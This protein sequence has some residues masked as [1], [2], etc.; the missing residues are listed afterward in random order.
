M[1]M[2]IRQVVTKM[3]SFT[4]VSLDNKQSTSF[5]KNIDKYVDFISWCRWYPD[6][7]LDLIKPKTGGITLHPD[8]RL[9]LRCAVRFFALYGCFPRGWGKTWNEV[10]AMVIV[11]IFYPNMSNALTA[12]T[13]DNAAE[14]L[15]D[16]INELLKQY[17]MLEN[18]LKKKPKFQRGD[19]EVSLKDGSVLDVLANSQ[20]SKGQRRRRLSVEESALL[21]NT[22]F[23]DALKPIVEVSRYTCGKLAIVDPEELNQQI[24]FFTTPG[25]RGSD[26]HTRNLQMIK[27][28]ADLKGEIVLGSNWML[29]CWY[30]RGSSKS[31][32]LEKKKTMSP[33]AFDQNYGG[34]WTGS[35]D[36]ALV[37]I[38]RLMACR[39]L[40][41]PI[42]EAE[43]KDDEYYIGVDVA[44]SQNTNNNQSSIAIGKVN[45]NSNTGHMTS[46][47]IVNLLNVSNTI[48]FTNQACIIKKLKKRYNAQMV[49]LDGNGL[50]TG[51]VDEILKESIDPV[52]QEPLGCWDTVNTDNQPET[53]NAEKCLYDL[54]ATGMQTQ[55]I[56][57]FMSM[58]DSGKLR[59]LAKKQESELA[60]YDDKDLE[61][62]VVP[63]IQT[64]LLFEEVSNL[65]LKTLPSG[66]LTVEKVVGKLNKDRFS[67]L[68]YL[69]WYILEKD[70]EIVSNADNNIANFVKYSSQ[71]NGGINN[72][73]LISKIFR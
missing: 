71:I 49:I 28:M 14:L 39:V 57:D 54:K 64:D 24:N 59:L 15:K 27:N 25:W 60:V 48:N 58:I 10:A 20:N 51:L 12:Q 8:Q 16:K 73:N 19:A 43:N 38:N 7:F 63:F 11:G 35:S 70:K 3:S 68:A 37:N 55:I 53:S 4:N 56:T 67:C 13:K 17:P 45:R 31:Q 22:T 50:G 62:K 18:E 61:S 65:K 72:S 42:M 29:G 41:T 32:I 1:M 5:E 26:E 33:I 44:R 36:H 21:D 46:V 2:I 34:R 47:D 9:F 30:G 69:L 66:S 52:T 23:E 6:L 40:E